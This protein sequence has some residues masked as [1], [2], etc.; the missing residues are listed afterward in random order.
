MRKLIVLVTLLVVPTLAYAGGVTMEKIEYA[1]WKNCVK[2]SNGEIELVVTTDVGP[3]VIRVGFVGGQNLFK[4]NKD[5][6][7]K[8]GG[9]TWTPYGGHRFWHAPEVA[10]RTYALDNSPVKYEWNGKTLKLI[11]PVEEENRVQKQIE[12]TLDAEENHATLVHRL[13]NNNPWD[14]EVAPWCLSVMK[15]NGRAIFPH[16]EYRPHPDYLLPARPLV[17]WH[18]TDMTD[19]RW[20]WGVRYFQLKQD[21]NATTKQK[22]GLMNTLG[23]AAYYLDGD[24]FLK[25]F[26]FDPD[27]TYPDFG[28]NCEMYTDPDMIEVETVG[29]LSKL[30]AGGAV[31]HVE[32]WFLAKMELTEEE[33]SIDEN[34]L[35]LVRKTDS[36]MTK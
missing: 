31:E 28:C 4:E 1:G 19:P 22:L 3:R 6:L 36:Y 35:P 23:W 12:I 34:V 15:E 2:L 32:H 27:A 25:R 30:A 10:P 17:L 20:V 7:G 14:I 11:Q 26:P 16:E 21:P 33:S 18:Y 9:D 8:T 24:L 13:I 29:P 5:Q